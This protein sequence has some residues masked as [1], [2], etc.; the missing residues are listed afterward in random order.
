MKRDMNL[1]RA[2][3]L[4][5]AELPSDQP[6]REL[7][8]IDQPTFAAH[9]QWMHEAGLVHAALSPKDSLRPANMALV[10]RLTWQGCEFADA[11]KN[12]TLWAKAMT[13]VIKP[14]ASWTFSILTDCLKAEIT[15][16]IGIQLGS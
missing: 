12:D 9:A 2:I 6:L 7:P 13:S 5:T 10:Y 11:A 16:S 14:S 1:I 15:R 3:A 4:A 8:G